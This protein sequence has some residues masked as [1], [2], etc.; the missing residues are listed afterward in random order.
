M[1]RRPSNLAARRLI[2]N[3]NEK[4]SD[5]FVLGGDTSFVAG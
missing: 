2:S 5:G 4:V 1:T 3:G